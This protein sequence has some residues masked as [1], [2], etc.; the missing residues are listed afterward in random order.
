MFFKKK[1]ITAA[2]VKTKTLRKEIL[3]KERIMAE[4]V[5]EYPVELRQRIEELDEEV[6][7]LKKQMSQLEEAERGQVMCDY[8][9]N[10]VLVRTGWAGTGKTKKTITELKND[11][12][13][14]IILVPEQRKTDYAEIANSEIY[15]YFSFPE[16]YPTLKN[17]IEYIEPL[18]DNCN[19]D[20]LILVIEEA[21]A[22]KNSQDL[23]SF[24]VF[25]T[26]YPNIKFVIISQI[27]ND[28]KKISTKQSN[29][30]GYVV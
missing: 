12:R 7:S 3:K 30:T 5:L 28:E 17:I 4:L 19:H 29:E 11:K 14:S 18:L 16:E 21:N 26:Q 22:F 25:A 23:M 6:Y 15:E 1:K 27:F 2:Q 8:V 13:S 9:K 24:W 20:K 10:N